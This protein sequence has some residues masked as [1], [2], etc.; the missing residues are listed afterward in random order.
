MEVRDVVE[1]L[2]PSPADRTGRLRCQ[3]VTSPVQ[4]YQT[5]L[6]GGHNAVRPGR[7]RLLPNLEMGLTVC[8]ADA[9]GCPT[10]QGQP[11]ERASRRPSGRRFIARINEHVGHNLGFLNPTLYPLAN[12]SAFH[13]ADGNGEYRSGAGG[14]GS[15]NENQ[16]EFI[17]A[18]SLPDR[19][20]PA[21]PW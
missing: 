20:I 17:M 8:E 9:G 2:E 14:V 16:L 21:L 19:Q 6:V 13:S 5:A 15:P 18:G 7:R 12:S 10:G 3:P 4:P 11:A 1:R